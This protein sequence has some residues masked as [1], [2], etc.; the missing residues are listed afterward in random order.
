MSHA[1]AATSSNRRIDRGIVAILLAFLF[2]LPILF[3]PVVQGADPI[4][5]Y[6]WVRAVVIDGTL[7]VKAT[8]EH[9]Q[10]EPI[11][12]EKGYTLTTPTGYM[13]N[14]W[15]SGAALLWLPFFLAAHGFVLLANA[16]GMAVPAD[17]FSLPYTIAAGLG[18]VTYT[19]V[20]M[21]ALY[22]IMRRYFSTEISAGSVIV[23]MLSTPLVFYTFASPFMTHALDAFVGIVFVYLWLRAR[24]RHSYA[25]QLLVGLWVGL[26]VWLRTQNILLLLVPGIQAVLPVIT[27]TALPLSQR[28][29]TAAKNVS[30]LLLGFAILF[31]PLMLFWRTVYGYWIV[32]TYAATQQNF[33]Q[34][35]QPHL[36]EVL[37]SSNRGLFI[38]SPVLLVS[39]LG[40]LPLWRRDKG[41]TILLVVNFLLQYYLIASLVF[42][43]GSNAFGARY[44]VP[45]A[46]YFGLGLAAGADYLG[47]RIGNKW[48]LLGG[49]FLIVWNLLLMLQY[50]LGWVPRGGDVDL[51]EMVANQWRIIPA[52]LQRLS[53]LLF[54]RLE[55]S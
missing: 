3:R 51:A 45:S 5:Y 39:V 14:Q 16:A 20:G 25:S 50:A 47:R 29:K 23:L 22:K 10:G 27:A 7:D 4:G 17:G 53:G 38:W 24:E 11:L 40:T 36:L 28:I 44:F 37:F 1:I 18:T 13:H 54:N 6:S 33:I 2:C 12:L 43:S 19:L 34:P 8:W 49:G 41:L 46:C 15:A 52:T 21:I 42:W 31:L 26:A 48:L 55:S 30:A 32:N 35:L 9:Y